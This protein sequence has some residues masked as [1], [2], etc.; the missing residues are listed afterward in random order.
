L[1]K[2]KINNMKEQYLNVSGGTWDLSQFTGGTTTTST[3]KTGKFDWAGLGSSLLTAGGGI[4]AS[5]QQR[6]SAQAQA[7]ALIAQG[8]SQIEVQKLILE[9]KRL[10]LELAKSG[11]QAGTGAGNK[12]LYIALG[13]GAVVVLGVVIFAVTRKRA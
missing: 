13:V 11:G 1:L 12:T 2:I 8:L 6:K 9:G 4:Y 5:E 7:D 3:P 10:D